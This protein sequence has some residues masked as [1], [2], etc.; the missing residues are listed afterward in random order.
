MGVSR[1]LDGKFGRIVLFSK[2]Q[3]SKWDGY[4]NADAIS[5]LLAPNK[6]HSVEIKAAM[7]G[8]KKTRDM[9]CVE[10]MQ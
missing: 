10:C 7:S 3:L 5:L 4:T 2:C 6:G 9:S 8:N 1:Q